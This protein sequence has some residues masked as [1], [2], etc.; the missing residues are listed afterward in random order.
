[1]PYRTTGVAPGLNSIVRMPEPGAVW[2]ALDK[3]CSLKWM[4]AEPPLA[5]MANAAASAAAKAAVC[6]M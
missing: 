2:E 1:M 3:A 4:S 5:T 6:P